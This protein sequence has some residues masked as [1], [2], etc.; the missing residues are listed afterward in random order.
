VNIVI[1]DNNIE[2]HIYTGISSL[3]SNLIIRNNTFKNC[4]YGVIGSSNLRLEISRNTFIGTARA[5]DVARVDSLHN[6]TIVGRGSVQGIGIRL[7]G[8]TPNVVAYNN[9]SE[10][11]FGF[12]LAYTSQKARYTHNTVRDCGRAAFY[13]ALEHL[14]FDN[15]TIEATPA[16]FLLPKKYTVLRDNRLTGSGIRF[17]DAHTDLDVYANQDIDTSNKVNDHPV[18]YIVDGNDVDIDA[19]KYGQ[20]ILVNCSGISMKDRTATDDFILVAAYCDNLTASGIVLSSTSPGLWK[21]YKTIDST[22]KDGRVEKYLFNVTYC[23]NFTISRCTFVDGVLHMRSGGPNF[24]SNN[25]FSTNSSNPLIVHYGQGT[26]LAH[27]NIT[28]NDPQGEVFS[29]LLIFP[30]VTMRSNE[31]WGAGIALHGYASPDWGALDIDVSN[32]LSGKPVMY[33]HSVRD[34][35]IEGDYGQVII[36]G[37]TN[38]TVRGLVM[39]EGYGGCHVFRSDTVTVTDCYFEDQYGIALKI[40]RTNH[41]YIKN[42]VFVGGNSRTIL[43][44]VNEDIYTNWGYMTNNY[45]YDLVP[46]GAFR[47]AISIYNSGLD[48]CS[49]NLFQNIEGYGIRGTGTMSVVKNNEFVNCTR[50]AIRVNFADTTFHHNSFLDNFRGVDGSQCIDTYGTDLWD[51]AG[52][53]NYWSDYEDRFPL[54]TNDGTVWNTPY[55]IGGGEGRA[56]R[57]PLVDHV[58][59]VSPVV[60]LRYNSTLLPNIWESFHAQAF[61]NVAVEN[62]SWSFHVGTNTTNLTGQSVSFMYNVSGDFQI[63]I[64]VTDTAGNANVRIFNIQ[65]I[66]NILPVARTGPDQNVIP[67]TTVTMDGS[68]STDDRCI[69]S[70]NWTFVYDGSP[71]ELE[72]EIVQF[73]FDEWGTYNITLSVSDLA[74]NRAYDHMEV[75]VGDFEAPTASVGEDKTVPERATLRLSGL[76]S[77][78]NWRIEAYHWTVTTPGG[79]VTTYDTPEIAHTFVEVGVHTVTLRVTDPAGLWDEATIT[80]TVEDVIPPNAVA[81]E[82]RTVGQHE[83]VTLDGTAS[84]DNL[85]VVNWTW[86]ISG[87]GID[88][89]LYGPRVDL[90]FP[91]AGECAV[92]LTVTDAAGNQDSVSFGVTVRDTEPPSVDAGRDVAVDQG[93]PVDLDG[94][95]SSDNV[96]IAAWTWTFVYDGRTVTRS[97]PYFSYTFDIPGQYAV[98]LTLVDIEGNMG[99]DTVLV[100]VRD[101][102][103]PMALAGEDIVT[104]QHVKVTFDAG[105]S[106]DNVAVAGW[107]WTFDYGGSTETL[108]GEQ[109]TFT[110]DLAGTYSITLTVLDA[111]G[112]SAADELVVTV[113]DADP[114]VAVAGDDV[115]IK[116][117]EAADLSA[118]GSTDNVGVTGWTWTFQYNGSEE[119]LEGRTMSFTFHVP[120][121]YT[122]TLEVVDAAGL[123]ATDT[124]TVTVEEVPDDKPRN[125]EESPGV[126]AGFVLLALVALAVATGRR[127]RG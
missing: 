43:H 95:S 74:G 34:R 97:G 54:A 22:F 117:G 36:G 64:K 62:Y 10:V 96:D 63:T 65:V 84:T 44:R 5:I 29:L 6:N 69:A 98:T 45:F 72:G 51:S 103:G 20:V 126:A 21:T 3:Y 87:K 94:T 114:P 31:L 79:A 85:G 116:E 99:T 100:N 115:T 89:I 109:A 8:P 32:T 25:T 88:I 106:T 7:R 18:L 113:T 90:V 9:V 110:F 56:D 14:T 70:H 53:G 48:E 24:V 108:E 68:S 19:S 46:K 26:L 52:E 118:E 11:R 124:V 1:E 41:I 91:E 73:T 83:M 125:E 67:G 111:A 49:N 50:Q 12:Y 112:N 35:I 33:L 75:V 58:D 123:K 59:R 78:D 81:G 60:F 30:S 82:D 102:M 4:V 93:D 39:T 86:T 61:D 38:V 47:S 23:T 40:Y 57:F 17:P 28:V 13:V 55:G 37:V 15:N 42:N 105:S 92:T 101:T 77:T 119:R 66:D 80:V 122:I 107:T 2:D 127:R 121:T 27:N 76:G 16:G 104:D 120:G 71:V